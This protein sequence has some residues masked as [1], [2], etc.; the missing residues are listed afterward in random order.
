MK[1]TILR[2]CNLLKPM[3]RGAFVRDTWHTLEKCDIL[4]IRHD[5]DCGYS[6]NGKA[7]GHLI[8]SLGDLCANK[9]LRV[10]I[11]A[12]PLS[13][14]VGDKAWNSPASYNQAYLIITVFRRLIILIKGKDFA[15][16]WANYH[17]IMLCCDILNTCRPTIIIGIQPDKYFCQAG[18]ELGIPVYDL[19]HGVIADD[20][21]YYG[22]NYRFSTPS[23]ELPNGILCWDEQAR[24][25]IEKWGD[26]K[27]IRTIKIGNPWFL[28]FIKGRSCDVLVT[29]AFNRESL[30]DNS[31][32]RILV[33]LQWGMEIYYSYTSFNGVMIDALEEVILDT[34]DKYNWNLRLHP[35]QLR[36]E[37]KEATL[38]YL[39]RTFGQEKMEEWVQSSQVP[40]PIV[41]NHTDLHMTDMSTVVIEAAWMGVR[42][43]MLNMKC[44]DF[45]SHQI[46]LGIAEVL[47]H[48]PD[49]IKQWI[50][51]T[52]AKGR[53]KPTMED[54]SQ[55]LDD[56]IEEI[57]QRCKQ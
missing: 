30:P 36:D 28:R 3:I 4:L 10:Q 13:T 37:E 45:F 33:S 27:G 5:N 26:S 17:R 21:I 18:K 44:K 54:S 1:S 11:L 43:G 32:P 31:Q 8:D 16:R 29:E 38:N 15:D 39:K 52:L 48:D 55:A 57:V 19:Q 34:L 14:L 42:S 9:S 23:E 56:F 46:S 41:L 40:L 24:T 35:V 51:D 6:I 53:A 50:A 12:T 7:Y 22:A 25:A 47:P 2:L 49:T 20:N